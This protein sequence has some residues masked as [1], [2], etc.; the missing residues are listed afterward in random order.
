MTLSHSDLI[1]RGLE[2][3]KANYDDYAQ[4]YRDLDPQYGERPDGL[5]LLASG[6]VH[7]VEAKTALADFR[8]DKK[9][10]SRSEPAR[11]VGDF[12]WYVAEAGVIPRDELPHG[13]GLIL[14]DEDG[15][16]FMDVEPKVMY[17]NTRQVFRLLHIALSGRR[18]AKQGGE[19]KHST[20]HQEWLDDVVGRVHSRGETLASEAV[21]PRPAVFRTNSAAVD[22]LGEQIRN[23]REKRIVIASAPKALM[24][25]APAE[26]KA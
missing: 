4:C 26:V 2:F 7:I 15:R 11:G 16:S 22:Y 8:A 6:I 19:P 17:Q 3:V 23:G 25:L 9:K 21:Q 12:R 1:D 13:W 10:R 20:K 5:V 18:D 14:A 24:R